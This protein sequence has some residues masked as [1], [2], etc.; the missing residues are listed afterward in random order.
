[1]YK[2]KDSFE[3][4]LKDKYIKNFDYNTFGNITE[5]ARGAFG[6]VYRANSI[7]LRKHVAL[8]S[9]YEN[10]ELFYEK[11]VRELTNIMA[12]NNHDNIINFYGISIDPKTQTYYLVLQYA[13]DGDLRTYLRNNFK[14]LDWKTIINM[15]KDIASGLRCIHDENIVHKDLHSRNI[16][17]HEE[18]L[19]ITDLGL[20]QP[21]DAN[22]N[23]MAG[24]MVAY[25]DPEYLQDPTK[26]KR[27]K[28]S[29]IYSLGVL[30]WE[31]SSG[32]PPFNNISCFKI[33]NL[34]TSGRREAPINE[35]PKDY[36]NIYSSAW[37]ID[38]N[39][40][41]TIKNIFDSLENIKLENIYY[42]T[43]DNQD[44]QL[45]AYINNQSQTVYSKDSVSIASSFNT[46]N[47]GEVTSMKSLQ[48]TSTPLST[49][50]THEMATHKI[51]WNAKLKGVWAKGKY[52]LNTSIYKTIAEQEKYRKDIVENDS[53]LTKNEKKFL[54]NFLHEKY[55]ILRIKSNSIEKKQCNN[56][57]NWHQAIQ[58]CEFCIRKY[59]KNNFK[60]WTSGNN[61]LDKLIQECQQTTILPNTVIEWISCDQF[62]NVK[63][64]VTG[65]CSDFYTAIWK[66][67]SYDKWNSERQILERSERQMI[68]IKRPNDSSSN[69]A[70]WLQEVTLSFT[71]D[72]TAQFLAKCYGITKDPTTQDYVLVFNYY[73]FNLRNFLKDNYQ[74]LT[75]LQ[76]YEIIDHIAMSLN[77]IHEQGMVHINLHS[78]NILYSAQINGWKISNLGL[79]GPVNKQLDKKLHSD[80]R[81][82]QYIAPEILC[83]G[84]HTTKSDVYSLGI[85][86][87]EVI[88][89][90]T[91]GN[92]NHKFYSKPDFSL[93]I[94]NGYRPKIYRYIPYEYATLMKQCW[95]SNPDNRPDAKTIENEMDSLIRSLFNGKNEKK[96]HQCFTIIDKR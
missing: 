26:Y 89:G 15:A 40:R 84:N 49:S 74:S 68:V 50:P 93:A 75:L 39:Q 53:S 55:D 80:Y 52:S 73:D 43:K 32:R 87:W 57:Q 48:K 56:C 46:S 1:M 94:I 16:L 61:E 83:E 47:L 59:L 27:N 4:A 12:V 69:N 65:I 18:R 23:S 19:L 37:K 79:G 21:L 95:D 60:N 90:E 54:L 85:I 81:H 91:H 77:V 36:V 31:L 71:L 8:K 34:V 9:L 78:R 51:V 96:K 62:E 7:N 29:D 82:L 35:T 5:I 42:E 11:F 17:V 38:S 64:L 45:E 30:F 76:K 20:S 33:Y 72:N 25:T 86:M 24:G 44:I 67:G 3:S 6:T 13:K 10:D 63:Y 14:S 66:D 58:Y 88:T 28:T 92:H 70:H 2:K 41:P 22:S